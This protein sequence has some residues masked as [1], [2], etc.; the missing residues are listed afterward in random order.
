MEKRDAVSRRRHDPI[1]IGMLVGGLVFGAIGA[2][3]AATYSYAHPSGLAISM[4]WWGIYCGALGASIG[5][6]PGLFTQ[7]DRTGKSVEPTESGVLQDQVMA[8]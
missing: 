5:A 7:R 8:E 1:L 2:A 6:L 4:S 3:V